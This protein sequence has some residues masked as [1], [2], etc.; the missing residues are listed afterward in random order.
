[1][2]NIVMLVHNRPRLTRQALESLDLHTREPFT[3]TI[4]D[5]RSEQ[6]TQ[7]VLEDFNV[8]MRPLIMR[9]KERMG[10]GAARNWGI[11]WSEQAFGR[12]DLLYLC[13]ND[14]YFSY[15]W[16]TPLLAA[17]PLAASAGFRALG[18]YAHA[19]QRPIR[20][21]HAMAGYSVNELA[22][23]GLLSWLMAWE[24]WD[25]FGPF[26]PSTTINGSEDWNYS[27]RIRK[28]GGMVGVLDPMT[29]INCGATSSDGKPCPGAATLYEQNIPAGVVI[30]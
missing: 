30:E 16:D 23:L 2:L 8:R 21:F 20:Q 3:L 1:M 18:A 25:Q 6:P 19:Y 5:D 15:G 4:V 24:T 22:A 13:D 10:P 7:E 29:V 28:S 12:G 17:W 26:E 9:P 14:C 11:G 27:Q